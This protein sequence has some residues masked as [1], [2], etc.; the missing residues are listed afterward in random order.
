MGKKKEC[1][2]NTTQKS[3]Y[4]PDNHHAG[5]RAIIKVSGNQHRWLAS[6]Y[7]LELGQF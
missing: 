2:A 3:Q 7:D 6:G 1:L 4:P 5:T